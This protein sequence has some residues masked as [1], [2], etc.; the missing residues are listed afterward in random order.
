[1]SAFDKYPLGK[2]AFVSH[3]LDRAA[4]L[5]TNDEKLFALEGQQNARA[6]VVYRDSL[7]TKQEESG[8]RALLSI[9]EALDFG[10][11]PGT[12]FLGLRD[13]APIFGMGIAPAAAEKLIG[14]NDVAITELRGMAMQGALPLEQLSAIAMAKSLVSW[15][16]RHG[17]C[18]NCG[19]RTS[20]KEGGWK[21]ECASCKA[22]HFPRTDPVVIMLVSSGDK[23]LLGRQKQF[24]PGMYSCLAGFVEAAET[25]ED[26]VRRE[27]FEESGIRVTD[28]NYYMTQPWPYPSSLMIGCTAR[29]TNEDIVVDRTEL[30]DARWFDR[31]ELTLMHK[32]QHPD[33]LFAAHPFA[34][35]HHLIGQWLHGG[36]HSAA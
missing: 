16:Q 31:A 6:Y 12:I 28:V 26:A 1:M 32:R 9:K 3:V 15:H 13:S 10:A 36:T 7:L 8:P 33:G 5:R 35:A 2:P 30:E 14:R 23:A 19:A 18:A 27:I 24:M 21:R 20:M 11:N 22:E 17:F 4:H 25:I 34:I 29:A